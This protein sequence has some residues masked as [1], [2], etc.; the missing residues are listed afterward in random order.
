[1]TS[2]DMTTGVSWCIM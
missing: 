2:F 1:M